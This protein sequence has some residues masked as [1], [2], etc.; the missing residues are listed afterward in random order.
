MGFRPRVSR[1]LK[2]MD[3]RI[4]RPGLMGLSADVHA[5]PRALPVGARRTMARRRAARRPSDGA[6]RINGA[7]RLYAIVGDPIAQVKSPEVFSELFARPA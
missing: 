6:M 4:F 2:T 5:K 1:D 3:A 7:T